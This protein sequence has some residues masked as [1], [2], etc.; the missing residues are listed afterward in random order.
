M[1]PHGKPPGHGPERG[2]RG[3]RSGGDGRTVERT[4]HEHIA[5][6]IATPAHL[7]ARGAHQSLRVRLAQHGEMGRKAITSSRSQP[8]GDPTYPR[9]LRMQ[10]QRVGKLCSIAILGSNRIGEPAQLAARPSGP[11][12]PTAIPPVEGVTGERGVV[13]TGARRSAS[14]GASDVHLVDVVE[15]SRRVA[16]QH[17]G[18]PGRK[19]RA[20]DH[21]NLSCLGLGIQV[22][23]GSNISDRVAGGHDGSSRAQVEGGRLCVGA[24]RAREQHSVHGGVVD[25]SAI[26]GLV[27]GGKYHS[28]PPSAVLVADQHLVHVGSFHQL[29]SR[30][31]AHRTCPDKKDPHSSSGPDSSRHPPC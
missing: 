7:D 14:A 24:N 8:S 2:K 18:E 21:R 19:G 20:Y 15:V 17:A 28:R 26:G 13:L 31:G 3:Y 22:E 16:S 4:Q 25:G 6:T 1:R 29:A 30:A 12:V 27:A 11:A 9:E 10:E 5:R 23:Q